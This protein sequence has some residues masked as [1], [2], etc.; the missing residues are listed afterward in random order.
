MAD[1]QSNAGWRLGAMR[2]RR[3]QGPAYMS[4]DYKFDGQKFMNTLGCVRRSL[5]ATAEWRAILQKPTGSFSGGEESEP[6]LG[7]DFGHEA[8][9]ETFGQ[10]VDAGSKRE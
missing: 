6:H 2:W 8:E 10:N 3:V 7:L 9:H 1:D 5:R 4:G